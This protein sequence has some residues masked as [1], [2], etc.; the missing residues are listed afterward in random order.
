MRKSFLRATLAKESRAYGFTIAF[1]GSGA[2]LIKAHGLPTLLEAVSYGFGAVLGFGI[3]SIIAYRKALGTPNY[4][5][6]DIVILSMIHYVAAL[7]PIIAA[8]QLNALE[9]VKA[10]LAIGIAASLLYNLGMLVEELVS[11]EAMRIERKL[12]RTI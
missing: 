5:E 10:H 7:V 12:I 4:Q 3:L 9:P 6:N 8:F 11:E 2:A 1:W